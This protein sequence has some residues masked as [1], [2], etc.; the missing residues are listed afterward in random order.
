MLG[1]NILVLKNR[2]KSWTVH[3]LLP[4]MHGPPMEAVYTPAPVPVHWKEKVKSDLDRDVALGVLEEVGPN[5]LSPGVTEWWC[6]ENITEIQGGQWTFRIS[7]QPV[8]GSVTQL[9]PPHYSRKWRYLTTPRKA[10]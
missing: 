9:P 5:N 2:T 1:N 3:S 8:S 4:E 7:M 10:Y 6:A